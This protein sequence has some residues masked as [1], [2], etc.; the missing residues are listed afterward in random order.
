MT[1]TTSHASNTSLHQ[2]TIKAVL[3]AALS[4]AAGTALATPVSM[5]TPLGNQAFD[6]EAFAANILAPLS[7]QYACFTASALSACTPESLQA[8]VLGPDL[9]TGLTLGMDGELMLGFV[10]GGST[11]VIWEAGHIKAVGDTRNSLMSVHTLAGWSDELAYTAD[12]IIPVLNDT[13]PSGY[14]TNFSSFSAQD[15][16]MAEGTQFDALRIRSCCT[17]DHVD[18]LAVGV[19]PEPSSLSLMAMGLFLGL[20]LVSR[21]PTLRT[22]RTWLKR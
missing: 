13:Q 6:S 14:P 12:K 15:F 21:Q 9:S 10:N 1:H 8:A 7:G 2:F 3:A 18:L 19:I 17:Y 5:P 22:A 20:L 4:W 16:G 11:L